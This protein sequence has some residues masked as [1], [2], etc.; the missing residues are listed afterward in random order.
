MENSTHT[1]R[2]MNFVFQLIQ[3]SQVKSKAV[4]SWSSQKKK[5]CIF[6]NVYFVQRNFIFNICVLSQCKV[7]W[8]NFQNIYTFAH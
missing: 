4:M 5:E 6:C 3:E 1:F 7:Y 2:E 8:M